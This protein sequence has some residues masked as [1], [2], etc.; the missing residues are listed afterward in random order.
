MS[1]STFDAFRADKMGALML[2]VFFPGTLDDQGFLEAHAAG[3]L[4]YWHVSDC[5]YTFMVVDTA[6][7]AIIGMGLGDAYLRERTVAERTSHGVPWLEGEQRAPAEKVLS[8]PWEGRERLFG[9]LVTCF[10]RAIDQ[11][12]GLPFC[13]GG[14]VELEAP[15]LP[16]AEPRSF[17]T[18]MSSPLT[19]STKGRKAGAVIVQWGI[20]L[21]ESAGLPSYFKSSPS[22]VGLYKNTGFEMPDEQIV[23]DA[24]LLGTDADIVVP[25]VVRMPSCAKGMTFKERRET[26][27]PKSTN[28]NQ[29][30][31]MGITC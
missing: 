5:Q 20:D 12:A 25:L 29:L 14:R 30:P 17:Q 27:Y 22:T 28:S 16:S 3:T 24:A 15:T 7:G 9:G 10:F 21:G 1:Q 4:S 8:R 11:P 31:K 13:T 6:T 18:A 2:P 26:G 23:H 19:P